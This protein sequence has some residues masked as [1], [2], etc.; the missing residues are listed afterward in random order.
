MLG[1]TTISPFHIPCSTRMPFWS[2]P[3]VLIP[4]KRSFLARRSFFNGFPRLWSFVSPAT[5]VRLHPTSIVPPS[6][7]SKHRYPHNISPY[8]LGECSTLKSPQLL[9]ILDRISSALNTRTS[10]SHSRSN[11]FLSNGQTLGI[12]IRLAHRVSNQ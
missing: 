1:L 3:S 11:V 7:G 4:L 10:R 8:L 2:Q 12:N 6:P 5:H 9:N